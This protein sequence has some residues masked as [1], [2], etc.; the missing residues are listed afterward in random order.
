ME[1]LPSGS[2]SYSELVIYG[3]CETGKGRDV[4]ENLVNATYNA[5]VRTVIGF[6]KSVWN[7]ETNEWCAAFFHAIAE[8]ETIYSACYEADYYIANNW[9]NPCNPNVEITTDSWYI[10]GEEYITLTN[11]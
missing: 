1:S 10:A 5:G 9:Y 4:E 7:S 11:E 2:L 6:E 8:G 3:A